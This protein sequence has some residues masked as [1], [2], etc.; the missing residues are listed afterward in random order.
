MKLCR[1]LDVTELKHGDTHVIFRS[2]TQADEKPRKAEVKRQAETAKKAD[3][4]SQANEAREA[5][6]VAHIM[7]PEDYED[8][9]ARGLLTREETNDSRTQ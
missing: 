2:G 5:I 1:K 4:Q 9:V 6:D 3:L 7:D 8:A